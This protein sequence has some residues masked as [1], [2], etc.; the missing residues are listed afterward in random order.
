MVQVICENCHKPFYVKPY[1]GHSAR[2]C[3][4]KCRLA[5]ESVPM[6]CSY[7]GK[8]FRRKRSDIDRKYC[9]R[10]CMNAARTTKATVVCEFCG[11]EFRVY[12][13]EKDT[14]RFCSREC[15]MEAVIKSPTEHPSWSGG[16]TE[17]ITCAA[18]GKQFYT[19]PCKVE[20]T[21]FCSQSC[22][23]KYNNQN[24]SISSPTSIESMLMDELDE[25]HIGY[26]FQYPLFAYVLDFAFP[27]S[28]LAV[29]ADGVY[30]H[31]LPHVQ[32][33]DER[34]DTDLQESGWTILRFTGD[35]IRDSASDCV[36]Q[37]EHA[38]TSL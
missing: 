10:R 34:K 4:R 1:R 18:C 8:P 26:K 30:W 23:A 32:E 37:I 28:C 29:E 2:F 31:G 36:D 20:T 13:S 33:R 22:R 7:C 19:W 35:E 38:L 3:S 11:K 5:F 14:R 25:R 21:K 16:K 15:Y 24:R 9:S 6:T 17:L 12:H 27:K